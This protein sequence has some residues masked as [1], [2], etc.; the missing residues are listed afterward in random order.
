MQLSQGVLPFKL[1]LTSERLDVIAHGGLPLILEA[2]RAVLDRSMYE[3]LAKRLGYA[4]WQTARRHLETLVLLITAG[5]DC[6][7]DV[8][9]LRADAGLEALVGYRLSSSTQLKQ[10]L[11]AFHQD[12]KGNRLTAEQD[13]ELSVRGKA[14]IRNEGPGLAVLAEMMTAVVATLH[15]Q[16]PSTRATLD[17]DATIIEAHKRGALRAYEGTTGYQPQMAWWAERE[18]W[19]E[20]EFRDGNVPAAYQVKSFLQ[21]AFAKLPSDVTARRLR[22]DSALYDEAA[23]TW[24]DEE[25]IEFAV[26][27]DMSGALRSQVE[28]LPE[29]A[30]A[31]YTT[32]RAYDRA[33][34]E[35]RQWAEVEFVPNWNRNFRLGAKPLRYIAIRV[36]GRQRDLYDEEP[37]TW[38]HF[39][40]VTN[41]DWN[42][43]RLLRW[44]REKQGTVEHA[45]GVMKNELAGG[46]LPCGRFGSNA[47]W[48]RI[49]ALV[50]N[51]L[52]LTKQVALPA[53][54][55]RSRPKA[56]RFRLFNIAGLLVRHARQLV[57]RISEALPGAEALEAARSALLALARAKS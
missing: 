31:D 22:A 24:A 14:T 5:G 52:A 30:W 19:V 23:L 13:A 53:S 47:A 40:I 27:A 46:T 16:R 7:D 11:Y 42:G 15:A 3:R 12:A 49:N 38:R 17:V 33:P 28:A 41:M 35:Q 26:S 36:R 45:H 34:N 39:A 4:K 20:D 57:L 1:E 21:R 48:W 56:L 51:L 54:M 18:V 6:V 2:L 55:Q 44:Q 29:S 37:D 9:T 43:L 25:G 8:N 32:L 10:F 50:H